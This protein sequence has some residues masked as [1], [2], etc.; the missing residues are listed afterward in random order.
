M[1]TRT[2]NNSKSRSQST[3]V[4]MSFT[5]VVY[6][7]ANG[8]IINERCASLHWHCAQSCAFSASSHVTTIYQTRGVTAALE[9]VLGLAFNF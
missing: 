2:K 7:G 4:T 8:A 6:F 9:A 1:Q 5:V 3:S